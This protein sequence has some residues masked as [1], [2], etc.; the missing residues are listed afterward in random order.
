MTLLIYAVAAAGCTWLLF[1][2]DHA[3]QSWRKR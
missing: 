1:T 3:I 2:L